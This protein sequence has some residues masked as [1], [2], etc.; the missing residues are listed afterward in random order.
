MW[1]GVPAALRH[2]LGRNVPGTLL[3]IRTETSYDAA[4]PAELEQR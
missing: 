1:L 3:G 4:E 2:R